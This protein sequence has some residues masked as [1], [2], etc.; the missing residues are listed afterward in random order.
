MLLVCRRNTIQISWVFPKRECTNEYFKICSSNSH[1]SCIPQTWNSPSPRDVTKWGHLIWM[2]GKLNITLHLMKQR[3]WRGHPRAMWAHPAHPEHS[4]IY[5]S[6]LANH[7]QW[8]CL[9]Y[10]YNLP[11]ILHIVP[12]LI[13]TILWRKCCYPYTQLSKQTYTR[14]EHLQWS[15]MEEEL[16]PGLGALKAVN[17]PVGW[18]VV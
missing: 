3:S 4:Y 8:Q 9:L 5:S 2:W 11:D 16:T 10:V 12:N 17:L 6:F 13:L 1:S 7:Y 14:R 15:V 18:V